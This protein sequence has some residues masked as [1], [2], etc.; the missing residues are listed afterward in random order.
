MPLPDVVIAGAGLIGL[1]CAL[2]L[3]GRGL[4]V[5]VLERGRAVR[6]AS[7]A[8]AGMLA[9]RDPA[10]PEAL[11]PL[12]DLSIGLYP[13]L[14]DG[15]RHR[16]GVDV[17]I[18]T[19][20]VLERDFEAHIPAG[21]EAV[22]GEAKISCACDVPALLPRGFT[23]AGFTRRREQ[24]LN[25]RQLG[26]AAVRAVRASSVV[27]RESTPVAC[28]SSS[29][30]GVVVR[31]AGET[32]AGGTY[33]DCTG[34]WSKGLTRPAKGQMLRVY[35]PGALAVEGK[36]N[37]VVRTEGVYLVPR[38]DGS[39]VIGATVEDAGF[40][41]AVHDGDLSALRARAAALVPR[42]DA[43]PVL[44]RWAGLRPDTPDHLPFLGA[45]GERTFVAAGHFRNGVLLAPA[46]GRVMAEL[47]MGET[48]R[49]DLEA[50]RPGRF[51]SEAA[52]RQQ[53]GAVFVHV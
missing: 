48:P 34:A 22:N 27:L 2:E 42:A 44:E 40:D 43:A 10:N 20:W 33:L 31:T 23:G 53:A 47:I 7:W 45:T 52:V 28:V 16:G 3:D 14:L 37:V 41:T 38:L 18:E 36:G 26:E 50:F 29:A 51:S 46:T 19:E 25:P 4:R 39:I 11:Q 5:M 12:A 17:P 1:A 6:E 32:F 13:A 30:Q 24:S 9:A 15:I 21:C 35:A 49:V 8:A